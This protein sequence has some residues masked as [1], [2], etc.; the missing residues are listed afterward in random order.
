M[1]HAR[2]LTDA[3]G[4]AFIALF[5][6]GTRDFPN[7]FLPSSDEA[8]SYKWTGAKQRFHAIFGL[9]DDTT[10]KGF[11]GLNIH[12]FH[13]TKHRAEIGPFYVTPSHQGT[14]AAAILLNTIKTYAKS[15][16]VARLELYVE[17]QNARP[18]AFYEKHGFQLQAT[19][20]DMVRIGDDYQDDCFYTAYL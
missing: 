6:E 15:Q 18:R 20:K 10:L 16:G 14:E 12:H 13:R 2:A 9:F 11:C 19:L 4:D 17:S 8:T 1:I 3:D 7:G 5:K